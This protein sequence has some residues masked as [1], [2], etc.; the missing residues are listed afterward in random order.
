ML[1][2]AREK[3]A[4][5]ELEEELLIY[6][7]EAVEQHEKGF[8]KVFRLIGFFAKNLD[9]GHFETFKDVKD[10]VLFDEEEIANKEEAIDEEQGAKEPGDDDQV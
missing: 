5:K 4:H 1:R 2:V 8:N 3:E 6:K 9:L 10:D 7:K